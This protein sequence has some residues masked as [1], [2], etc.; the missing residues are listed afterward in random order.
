MQS[1]L[2]KRIQSGRKKIGLTQEQLAEKLNVSGQ[3]VSKWESDISCPDITTLPLLADIIGVSVD[4]LLRGR[5]EETPEAIELV[6]TTEKNIDQM[7]LRI[8]VLAKEEGKN[9]TNVKIKIP[10]PVVKALVSSGMEI[11]QLLSMQG[12]TDKNVAKSIDFDAVMS[13][14][15][16]GVCGMLMDIQVEDDVDVKIVVE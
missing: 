13:M 14:I 8:L 6:D 15:D 4:E 11:G 10:I 3:A 16:N 5:K 9:D 7:F 12:V 2:G 1:S